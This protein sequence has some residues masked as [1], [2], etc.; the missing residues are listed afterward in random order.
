MFEIVQSGGWMM[1]PIISCSILALAIITERFI[2]LRASRIAPEELTSQVQHRSM[3][4]Q[5]DDAYIKELQSNSPLG[6]ILAAGIVNRN[7]SVEAMKESMNEVA[8]VEIHSMERFISGLGTIAAVTPLM[9]LLGTVLG[10]IKVFNQ[11]LNNGLG[12]ANMLAGGIS[13]ALISTAGGLLVAI[14]ALIMYRM[15]QR[16]IDDLVVKMEQQSGL[17]VDALHAD[18]RR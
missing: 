8:S 11:M 6:R 17:L 2:T 15:L 4:K 1:L 5:V 9:G 18:K 13:E 12:E 16:K 7:K 10:M 14:P 3:N